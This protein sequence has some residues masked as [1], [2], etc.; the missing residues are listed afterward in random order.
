MDVCLLCLLYNKDKKAKPGQSST[1]KVQRENKK[2]FPP[3]V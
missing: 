3:G 1:D 2:K